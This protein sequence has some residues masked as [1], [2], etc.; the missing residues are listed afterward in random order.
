[1]P[2]CDQFKLVAKSH[3]QTMLLRTFR[4]GCRFHKSRH[5]TYIDLVRRD[6]GLTRSNRRLVVVIGAWNS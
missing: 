5:T 2:L 6:R 3:C 1:M 4:E